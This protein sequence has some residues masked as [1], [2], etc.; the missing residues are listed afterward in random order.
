MLDAAC[1]AFC[2]ERMDRAEMA[3]EVDLLLVGQFLV[4]KHHDRVAG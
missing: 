4:A 1:R 3:G 2:A